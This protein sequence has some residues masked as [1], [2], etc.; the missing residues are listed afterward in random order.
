MEP[1]TNPNPAPNPVPTPAPAP[2]SAPV[3][4]PAPTPVTP[5]STPVIQPA[6][7]K[8]ST[9]S[10]QSTTA[11]HQGTTI[12]RPVAPAPAPTPAPQPTP[13]PVAPQPQQ[14]AP[15][16]TPTPAPVPAPA[17][18]PAPVPEPPVEE[19]A[20]AADDLEKALNEE[21]T[22][23]ET[24][25]TQI[26]APTEPI[27][28][29]KRRGQLPLLIGIIILVAASIFGVLYALGIISFG[30]PAPEPPKEATGP[31][32]TIFQDVCSTRNMRYE[33]V[34]E[35]NSLFASYKAIFGD[36]TTSIHHCI[37][38]EETIGDEPSEDSVEEFI[39]IFFNGNYSE[40]NK[41]KRANIIG[42][43]VD[44]YTKGSG[45]ITILENGTDFFKE[46]TVAGPTYT[47]VA[48][49][50]GS[51]TY[52]KI[53]QIDAAESIL[54]D[55][56]YPNRSNASIEKIEQ[57]AANAEADATILNA[58]ITFD[59]NFLNYI[60]INQKLPN[61][62]GESQLNISETGTTDLDAFYRDYLF[63][64][65]NQAGEH[66][67]F[68][69]S[70][71]A[72]ETLAMSKAVTVHYKSKCNADSGKLEAFESDTAYALTYIAAD[73]NHYLCVSNK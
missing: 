54:K 34:S 29:K 63:N 41:E 71:K 38:T 72:D 13:T 49:Y 22:E 66:Y 60:S 73:G 18:E 36:D 37:T 24:T 51:Y 3:T 23:I 7:V 35:G 43:Y 27:T 1:N 6:P 4:P 15:T 62:T 58:L 12:A 28:P 64:I 53:N 30:S 26:E 20:S 11:N 67:A 40:Y 33:E 44:A 31:T 2:T 57:T 55:L 46:I 48:V 25:V 61:I 17:P 8:M 50:K 52:M 39:T 70:A 14:P 21:T 19:T 65:K 47:Y 32:A 45:N 59:N 42:S 56:E 9:P 5:T 16:P 10:G 69:A 68:Q